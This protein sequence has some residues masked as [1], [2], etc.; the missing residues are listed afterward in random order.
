MET[1]LKEGQ[2]CR[3]VVQDPPGI[4]VSLENGY[5]H[6]VPGDASKHIPMG[7]SLLLHSRE[8]WS[9]GRHCC[10]PLAPVGVR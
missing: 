6:R 5:G 7:L 9:S 2:D 10:L 1:L 4:R 3:H 8:V